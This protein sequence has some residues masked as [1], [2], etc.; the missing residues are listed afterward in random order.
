M[1]KSINPGLEE[2]QAYYDERWP[3]ESERI[4]RLELLRLVEILRCLCDTKIDFSRKKMRICDLGCGRGWLSSQMT[5]LGDVVGVDLSQKG[6]EHAQSTWPNVQFR[7]AN[8]LEYS[9]SEPFDIVVSSEVIEHISDKEAYFATIRRILKPGGYVIITTPNLEIFQEYMKTDPHMQ[10]IEE[11]ISISDFLRLT[12]QNFYTIRVGS[13]L[14]DYMYIGKFRYVSAPKLISACKL[15]HVDFAR[16]SLH[17][18]MNWGLHIIFHG[19]L[20][21]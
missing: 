17:R 1:V 16:I 9:S 10:P 11:W 14:F 21:G 3:T 6:I 5:V 12:K 15:L 2:Q 8:I 18:I 19:Q 7:Q 13:F 20:R 4:N